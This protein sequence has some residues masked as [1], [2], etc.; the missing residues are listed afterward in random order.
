[1]IYVYSVKHGQIQSIK[2]KGYDHK[3]IN[4]TFKKIGTLR[5]SGGLIVFY[6]EHLTEGIDFLHNRDDHL[7]W[8]KLKHEFFGFEKDLFLSTAPVSGE[9]TTK[10]LFLRSIRLLNLRNI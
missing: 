10:S 6:K 2:F 9:T 4:R 1:M 8:M 5:D 7:M 3:M